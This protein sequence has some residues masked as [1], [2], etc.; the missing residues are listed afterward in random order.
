MPRASYSALTGATAAWTIMLSPSAPNRWLIASV[1][2]S[3]LV[4]GQLAQQ[5]ENIHP[6]RD[7]AE[8]KAEIPAH[9]CGLG[10]IGHHLLD[11]GD[12]QERPGPCIGFRRSISASSTSFR[13]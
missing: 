12:D 8:V 11:A 3:Q 7:H 13:T 9:L 6:R 2:C 4:G 10:G 5:G 1:I